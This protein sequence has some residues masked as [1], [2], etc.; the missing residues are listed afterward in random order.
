MKTLILK[1][2]EVFSFPGLSSWLL[3]FHALFVSLI[4]VDL[5]AFYGAAVQLPFLAIVMVN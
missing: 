1:H 3:P 4:S 2:L 5:A